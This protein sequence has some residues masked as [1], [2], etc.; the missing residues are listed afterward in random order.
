MAETTL[1]CGNLWLCDD[2]LFAAVYD[3]YT[4][5]DHR[6]AREEANERMAQIK[7]GL[8]KLGPHLVPDFESETCEGIREFSRTSCGCCACQLAG[9]RHRFAILGE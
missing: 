3:D 9:Q 5:L 2:C 4:P 7:E 8:D 1:E 6:Y